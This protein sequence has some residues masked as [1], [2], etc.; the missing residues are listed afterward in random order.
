MGTREDIPPY[1]AKAA[2]LF[3]EE[4]GAHLSAIDNLVQGDGAL[5]AAACSEISKRFHTI[6]GGAAFLKLEGISEPAKDGENEASS[7]NISAARVLELTGKIKQ[8][9]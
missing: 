7:G 3:F 2:E 9:L 5:S 1:L 4:L 6:R 8:S